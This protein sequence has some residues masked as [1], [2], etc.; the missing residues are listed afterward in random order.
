MVPLSRDML[1]SEE[2]RDKSSLSISSIAFMFGLMSCILAL[3]FLLSSSNPES[4]YAPTV[5]ERATG[6]CF[7]LT[8]FELAPSLYL[9]INPFLKLPRNSSFVDSPLFLGTEDDPGCK[10]ERVTCKFLAL[11]PF[12]FSVRV[13]WIVAIF[14]VVSSS[15]LFICSFSLIRFSSAC[16]FFLS[17]NFWWCVGNL[18]LKML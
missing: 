1:C 11:I 15:S 13:F 9:F 6:L 17:R 7:P 3:K 5:D 8:D 2:M 16:F 12:I 18:E 4:F 14:F 10:N